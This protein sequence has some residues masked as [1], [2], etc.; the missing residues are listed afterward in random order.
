[1]CF[2]Q[3]EFVGAGVVWDL[4]CVEVAVA[5]RNDHFLPKFDNDATSGHVLHFQLKWVSA[6]D[7]ALAVA[8]ADHIAQN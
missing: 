4:K 3:H 6:I 7:D 8:D 1:M 2:D 5:T